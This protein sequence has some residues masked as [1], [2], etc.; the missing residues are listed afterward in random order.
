M[1]DED[2]D[3]DGEETAQYLGCLYKGHVEG[4]EQSAV[5]VSLCHG[6]VGKHYQSSI[7][8]D[9]SRIVL[10]ESIMSLIHLP[11]FVLSFSLAT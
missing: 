9:F 2:D 4:D 5:A 11:S 3:D 8:R 7:L 1:G 10:T 6:M